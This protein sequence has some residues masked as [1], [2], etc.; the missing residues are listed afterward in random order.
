MPTAK[1]IWKRGRPY[2]GMLTLVFF[3]LPTIGFETFHFIQ[4]TGLLESFRKRMIRQMMNKH[5]CGK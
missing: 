5:L 3:L 2:L 4:Q 1:S